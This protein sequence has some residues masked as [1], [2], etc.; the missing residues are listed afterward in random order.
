MNSLRE[1]RVY[2]VIP[3]HVVDPQD[4]AV[5]DVVSAGLAQLAHGNGTNP[6]AEFNQQFERQREHRKLIPLSEVPEVPVPLSAV[7]TSPHDNHVN[8]D[9]IDLRNAS[10]PENASEHA[11]LR[12]PSPAESENRE[13]E[14]MDPDVDA[15]LQMSP[16]LERVDEKDQARPQPASLPVGL[17]ARGFDDRQ[18][19]HKIGDV[20]ESPSKRARRTAS[21]STTISPQTASIAPRKRRTKELMPLEFAPTGYDDFFARFSSSAK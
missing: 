3:G 10:E 12:L 20:Q 6:I 11:T 13:F 2:E 9:T 21:S 1:H 16:T 15:V 14:V 4:R 5:S 19:P 17:R 8:T 7:T 18:F